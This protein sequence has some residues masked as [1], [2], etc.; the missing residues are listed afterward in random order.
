[1][2]NCC[3]FRRALIAVSLCATAF[4]MGSS[5]DARAALSTESVV[6]SARE[7]DSSKT[8]V[9]VYIF[10]GY[11]VEP[12]GTFAEG[13]VV[14]SSAG[15]QGVTDARGSF[16]FVVEASSQVRIIEITAVGRAGENKL[17]N[18]QV[19]VDPQS[20]TY[21]VG[22]LTLA[23][24]STCSPSWLPT[25]GAPLPGAD[26]DIYALTVFDDGNGPALY[27]GGKFT[28]IGGF[29]ANRI[30]K[31]NGVRWRKLKTGTDNLVFALRVFDDGTGPALYAGGNFSTAGGVPASRIAKW[32]GTSWSSLGSGLDR[33]VRALEVFDD[34]GGDALYVGGN[35]TTAGGAPTNRV[36]K[37]NG[38]T[39]SPLNQGVDALV[40]T[41]KV[42][43]DG[44]GEALIAGGHFENA[45][46]TPISRIA[47]WDGSNWSSLASGVNDT[48][49]AL[50]LYDDGR[51]PALYAGGNF[52]IAGGVAV[53]R[54]ARWNGSIWET[55]NGLPNF[56]NGPVHSLATYDDGNGVALYIGGSFTQ[57]AGV[58]T[59]RFAKWDGSNLSSSGS[60]VGSVHAMTVF[61]GRT[62]PLLYLGGSFDAS[63]FSQHHIGVFSGVGVTPLGAGLTSYVNALAEFDDG[64]GPDLYAAG[65]FLTASPGFETEKGVARWDGAKWISLGARLDRDAWSLD[66][67]DDG[68]GDALYVGGRFKTAG[69]LSA[70]SIAKWDGTS[71]SALQGGLTGR[72]FSTYVF[73][74][75]TFDDGG[76][77]A[78]YA[79]GRFTT[80]DGI[81]ASNIA[82]WDGTTWTPVGSG[83]NGDVTDLHI[84]DDG[85][86]P[87]L[88]AAGPFSASGS[89]AMRGLARWDG[90]Q[91]LPVGT[92]VYGGT[93]R[94]L[95]TFDDGSGPTLFVGGHFFI[96]GTVLPVYIAKLDGPS[97]VKIG[98]PDL[99]GRV[100]ALETFDDGTGPALY[101]GGEFEKAGGVS[102]SRIARWDG[103]GWTPLMAGM[104]NDVRALL[105]FNDGTGTALYAGG[106]FEA[107]LDSGDARL[108]KWGCLDTTAPVL[109]CP[110]SVLKNERPN[111]RPGEPVAFHVSA[112]D[113]LDP[114]PT[115]VCTPESGSYFAPGTTVVN[116]T[117]T[118]ASGN[119]S[120]CQFTVTVAAKHRV[121]VTIEAPDRLEA[122]Q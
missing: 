37:W 40:R 43:D 80:A 48:V 8:G 84:F 50:A 87:A 110:T 6:V 95:E 105:S 53:P 52:T 82:K 64:T 58:S 59:N 10:E 35:F 93:A 116:C 56:T 44:T 49:E 36:A 38:S 69:G 47:K 27:A 120:T 74:L 32:D 23:T 60:L 41:L 91:W 114:S 90:S 88:Y 113:D 79:G 67:F 45:G 66:V 68:G 81:P 100:H 94:T 97:L 73:A 30:A 83:F 20:D 16:R 72:G 12:D 92:G 70:N 17:A 75:T 118:D 89:T 96:P 65:F 14:V 21:Q 51:G 76:G 99:D 86:G 46:G 15:G 28:T 4:S 31:W 54:I 62:G 1:M 26:N 112:T 103:S 63:I 111:T 19:E 102:L 7:I 29:A 9:V 121:R 115:V 5:I 85:N 106:L 2:K 33:A 98:G 34:G 101:V 42:F 39:W 13:A 25:F 77:S 3:A 108:A 117:A 18:R 55:L 22:A 119:Q 11:V 78:L 71:W 61:H 24:S 57:L 122:P 104:D 107:S 109:N